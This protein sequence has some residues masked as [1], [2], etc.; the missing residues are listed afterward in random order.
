MDIIPGSDDKSE[1]RAEVPLKYH[2]YGI[3]S[4]NY[5]YLDSRKL[6]YS[7]TKNIGSTLTLTGLN[8][9]AVHDYI[10]KELKDEITSQYE[11]KYLNTRRKKFETRNE[12]Y[13]LKS[14]LMIDISYDIIVLVYKIGGS[15]VARDFAN[16][17]VKNYT[18]KVSKQSY[19]SVL[20]RNASGFH[21]IEIENKKPR[22]DL[23]A[24]Y[25]DNVKSFFDRSLNF[26]KKPGSGL[27]LIN[28]PAGVGKTNFLSYLMH[29]LKKRVILIPPSVFGCL[30]QPDAISFLLDSC[31]GSV[32][33]LEDSEILLRDRILG[34]SQMSTLLNLSDGLLGKCINLKI[35]CTYNNQDKSL[36]DEAAL[37][38]GRLAELF[39]FQP[40]S[41]EK[42]KKMLERLG[43]KGFMVNQP[44][45][46][47]EIYA[48]KNGAINNGNN[49]KQLGFR[50]GAA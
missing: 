38:P 16:M 22:L 39:T 49:R 47:A 41:I 31:H 11:Q 13:F 1:K 50:N 9:K 18:K 5:N 48:K 10:E 20:A 8:P 6:F 24:D 45:T 44:M 17:L 35:I 28:G 19:V 33:L 43:V 25:N 15:N 12:I 14:K 23:V 40:L 42:S 26:L 29:F 34:N 27:L 3:F 4:E 32:L 30:D 21:L 36:I 7:F 37:R 2:G 46:L